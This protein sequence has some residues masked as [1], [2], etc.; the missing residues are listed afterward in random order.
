MGG[1]ETSEQG[2]NGHLALPGFV[3]IIVEFAPLIFDTAA[4]LAVFLFFS[5]VPSTK[6]K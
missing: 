6:Q 2:T 1:T 5:V 4:L 3:M